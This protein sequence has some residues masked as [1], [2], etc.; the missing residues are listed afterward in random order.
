MLSGVA[1]RRL[2]RAGRALFDRW[3]NRC[4]VC[5]AGTRGAAARVC[6]DCLARFA[7]AVPRCE[8][9]ALQLPEGV[10]VCGSC[11]RDPPPWSQA[12]AACDY[13]YPWDGLLNALKFHDA[14]DLAAP[15]AQRLALALRRRTSSPPV[16][17]LLPVPLAAARLC[18][19]GYNQAALLG[20]QLAQQL[21]LHT[22][23]QWLLRT[24]DTPHQTALPRAARLTNLRRAF[25]VEPLALAALRDRH[26]AL[27]DDVMT[28]GATAGELARVLH[29]AGAASV[30][31]WV[32]ARTPG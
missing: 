16:D 12:V 32:V 30:Q 24:S 1:S 8:R 5:R 7:P 20:R 9:C 27:V 11:L 14:I 6:D 17:L 2:I 13:A 4:A 26:V 3:P 18:E 15:L 21:G 10:A 22:E 25:S 29:A 28:T 23:P 31:V 19:R